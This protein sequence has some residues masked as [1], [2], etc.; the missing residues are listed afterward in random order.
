[1]LQAGLA[2]CPLAEALAIR[3]A[4]LYERRGHL[5]RARA[6][7]CDVALANSEQR[8]EF[9]WRALHEVALVEARSGLAS[10]AR[11]IFRFLMRSV[12]WYGPVYYDAY[13]FEMDRCGDASAAA[14]IVWRGLERVPRYGPL[15]FAAMRLAEAQAQGIAGVRAVVE[16]CLSQI[17]RE[18]VWRVWS[19][20][21]QVEE[22]L[23]H[24]DAWRSAY[25]QAALTCS[26]NM[27]WHVWISGARAELLHELDTR[28][29]LDALGPAAVPEPAA[30]E[31]GVWQALVDRALS[32]APDKC[33]A[34]VLLERA[35]LEELAGLTERAR[36]TLRLAERDTMQD[37][38]VYME[39]AL[40]ELRAGCIEAAAQQLCD[41]LARYPG[42]GRL[43]SLFVQVRQSQGRCDQAWSVFREAVTRVP[44]SGEV[45]C[46][47]ARLRM[48]P[49]SRYFDLALAQRYLAFAIEFTPQYGDSFIESLRCQMLLYGPGAHSGLLEQLC[50]NAD[51]NYGMLWFACKQ[52]AHDGP[53]DVF[54]H[55]RR[56]LQ[57]DLFRHR[58]LYARAML[59][60]RVSV[61]PTASSSTLDADFAAGLTSLSRMLFAPIHARPTLGVQARRA[62]IFGFDPVAA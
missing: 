46:E 1:M 56:V 40:L 51:P 48:N 15:W 62:L 57:A 49:L 20:L 38:K 14:Q 45:W 22:R 37:W 19:E 17:S 2:A 27:L 54:A 39:S 50:V 10:V 61:P 26:D 55:A 60:R 59:G 18:L 21:A 33:R 31:H 58:A 24:C 25:A 43:W 4:R 29:L 36:D 12:S 32:D 53:R 41:G 16:R 47:G 7:L 44:K 28:E 35:R 30:P 5:D 9:A 23:G 42:T 11:R 13:K 3:A 8:G 52:H 6:V 34:A